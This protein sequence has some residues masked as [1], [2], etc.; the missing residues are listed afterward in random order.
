MSEISCLET[1]RTS[2][3]DYIFL[4]ENL[5]GVV[6]NSPYSLYKVACLHL[7]LPGI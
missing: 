2:L 5:V 6:K 7:K 1:A 4:K 3:L